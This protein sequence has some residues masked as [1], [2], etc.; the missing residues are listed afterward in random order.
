[1][2]SCLN[3]CEMCEERPKQI[4][5]DKDFKEHNN[6]REV[7]CCGNCTWSYVTD[8]IIDCYHKDNFMEATKH[9]G[10]CDKWEHE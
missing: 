5:S 2:C 6:Y 1:M 3:G 7:E 8:E 10:H 9:Y 4:Y